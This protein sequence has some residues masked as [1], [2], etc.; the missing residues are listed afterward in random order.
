MGGNQSTHD[1]PS[2]SQTEASSAVSIVSTASP[3]PVNELSSGISSATCDPGI[4]VVN[5]GKSSPKPAHSDGNVEASRALRSTMHITL[6]MLLHPQVDIADVIDAGRILLVGGKLSR[7]D[8]SPLEHSARH[9]QHCLAAAAASIATDQNQLI[10]AVC[11]ARTHMQA[12]AKKL[13]DAQT[14]YAKVASTA[15]AAPNMNIHDCASAAR[16]QR[17][18]I[19]SLAAQMQE[20]AQFLKEAAAHNSSFPEVPTFPFPAAAVSSQ[21]KLKP[22][23]FSQ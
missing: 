22:K 11:S 6:P 18:D 5:A 19:M 12:A 16:T 13:Q 2:N 8:L 7:L 10:T 23:A 20:L 14:A 9:T 21:L 17:D 1:P 3:L 4:T 15:A